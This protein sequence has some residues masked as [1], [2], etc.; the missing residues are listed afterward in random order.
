MALRNVNTGLAVLQGCDTAAHVRVP[1]DPHAPTESFR[2]QGRDLY[3]AAGDV[4]CWHAAIHSPHDP[5]FDALCE[6][7]K[8]RQ[9]F[10]V[11]L[12]YTDLEGGQ[13]TITRFVVRP[14][15]DGVGWI[16]A[17]NRHWSLDRP[18]PR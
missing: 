13:R 15:S 6:V 4:G 12:L 7:A 16:T 18:D 11:D 1:E 9:P 17:A 10:G 2:L 14:K 3:I 8:N 5:A